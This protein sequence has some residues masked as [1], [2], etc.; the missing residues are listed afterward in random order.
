MLAAPS[1]MLAYAVGRMGCQV[2]G[3]GD[4]GILNSAYVSDKDGAVSLATNEQFQQQ[5]QQNSHFFT[6]QFESLEKVKHIPFKGFS[7][8]PT[9]SL[10]ILTRTM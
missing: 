8:C 5:L 4:W 3:D 10:P 2:S 7:F 6:S 9:G 1:L